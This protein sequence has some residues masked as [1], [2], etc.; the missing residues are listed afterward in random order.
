MAS[1]FIVDNMPLE[2][3]EFSHHDRI[4]ICRDEFEP[5]PIKVRGYLLESI[6]LD[7]LNGKYQIINTNEVVSERL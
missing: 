5:A 7:F 6:L 2:I 1:N 4:K 3:Y